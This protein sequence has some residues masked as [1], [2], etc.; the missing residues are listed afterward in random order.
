MNATIQNIHSGTYNW[1]NLESKWCL[2]SEFV[3]VYFMLF[4]D[5]IC[6][7]RQD[8]GNKVTAVWV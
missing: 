5:I 3:T 2:L 4:C 8:Y 1:H 6:C 7:Y